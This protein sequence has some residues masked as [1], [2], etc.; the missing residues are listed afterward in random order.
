MTQRKQGEAFSWQVSLPCSGPAFWVA[1]LAANGGLSGSFM[2]AW[3]TC[4]CAPPGLAPLSDFCSAG[5]LPTIQPRQR[6][7]WER[8]AGW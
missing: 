6:A 2:G 1:E 3:A 8:G 5:S 7:P 4:L